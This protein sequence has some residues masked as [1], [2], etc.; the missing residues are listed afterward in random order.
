[1]HRSNERDQPTPAATIPSGYAEHLAP[2]DLAQY[3][4]CFWT[5]LAPTV[6]IADGPA[7]HRVLPDG[8]VDIVL[9]FG[10]A[11]EHGAAELTEAIG[12]GSM[13]RPLLITRQRPG[14]YLGVRFRPGYAFAALGIPAS[15]LTDE[16]ISYSLLARDAAAELDAISALATNETRLEAMVALVRRRLAGA[17]AVPAS[18]RAAVHRISAAQGGLRIAALASSIG[19]TRHQLARL[20]AT[21]VGVTPK[22][23]ARVMRAHAVIARVDAARA[24]YPRRVDWSAIAY[25]LGYYDQPHF[26]DDFKALTGTT[27]GEWTG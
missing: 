27:P 18:V 20:F 17:C 10:R 8:C 2:T 16:R 22:T 5:R 14:L 25:E 4:A 1:M 12:V 24:A 15:E 23:F 19:I 3:V 7:I 21:H 11:G 26:I 13:T 9:G 6:A